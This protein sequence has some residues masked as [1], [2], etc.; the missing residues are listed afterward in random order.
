MWEDFWMMQLVVVGPVA[1]LVMVGP[2]VQL[3]VVGTVAQ[4][5]VVGPVAQLV[6]SPVAQLVVV[7][8]VAQLCPWA[9]LDRAMAAWISLH[10]ATSLRWPLSLFPSLQKT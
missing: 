6:V 5:V 2:V 8:P 9:K 10:S 4:L 3:V 1:Q 7:G